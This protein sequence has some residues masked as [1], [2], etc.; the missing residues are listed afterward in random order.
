MFAINIWG[1]TRIRIRNMPENIL[2]SSHPLQKAIVWGKQEIFLDGSYFMNMFF[3]VKDEIWLDPDQPYW[4]GQTKGQIVL[5]SKFN[6]A[7]PQ[8]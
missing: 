5:D 3:G 7:K 4:H 1:T 8:N 6:F 2:K